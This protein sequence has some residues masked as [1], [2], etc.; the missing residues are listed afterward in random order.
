ML[1]IK[2]PV[3]E[4]DGARFDNLDGFYDEV[5]RELNP[6]AEWGRNLDAFDEILRGGFGTPPRPWVL[7]WRNAG[8]SRERLGHEETAR[9]LQGKL[10]HCPPENAEAVRAD[11]ASAER[12]EGDTLFFMLVELVR[13]HGPEGA[14]G[15]DGVLLELIE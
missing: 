10:E 13:G 1:T 3:C 12:G 5:S 4:I 6:G 11:L 2:I 8:R 14:E 7:R 9:W 15:G